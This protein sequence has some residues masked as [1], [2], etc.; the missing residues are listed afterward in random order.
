MKTEF[1]ANQVTVSF[2][3]PHGWIEYETPAKAG[4]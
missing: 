2:D 3:M 4:E 1:G